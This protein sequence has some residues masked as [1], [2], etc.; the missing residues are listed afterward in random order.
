MLLAMRSSLKVTSSFGSSLV[1][2]ED[3]LWE[4][5]GEKKILAK[6]MCVFKWFSK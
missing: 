6:N 3:L 4:R 1:A 2:I 5:V